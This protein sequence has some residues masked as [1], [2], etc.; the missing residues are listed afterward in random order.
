MNILHSIILIM[1]SICTLLNLFLLYRLQNTIKYLIKDTQY[2]GKEFLK[3]WSRLKSVSQLLVQVCQ[4][5]EKI[6]LFDD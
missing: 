4:Q 3:L 2:N 6:D 5:L 1:L